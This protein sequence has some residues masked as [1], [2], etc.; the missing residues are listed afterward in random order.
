VTRVVGRRAVAL[1]WGRR[2]WLVAVAATATAAA[3]GRKPFGGRLRVRVPWA[4]SSLDPHAIG[5]PTAALFGS[6]IADPLYALDSHDRPYPTLARGLP[7]ATA[8]GALVRLRP[9][10]NTGRG[11]ALD[12]RDLLFS[13]RRARD[14]GAVALLSPFAKPVP[15]PHD[16]W[17]IVFPDAEPLAVARALT[18]PLTAL[19]PRGFSRLRPDGTGAFVASTGRK[20]LVLKRNPTAARGPAYLDAIEVT[21]ATDLADALRSFESGDADL[22]WLGR[23]L[24]RPRA[25]SIPFSAG[26]LG[27]VVLRTGAEAGSWGAPGV[28]QQLLDRI[29]TAALGHLGLHGLPNLPGDPA[30]GGKPCELLVASDAPHLVGIARTVAGVLTRPGHEIH[31]AERSRRDLAQRLHRSRF[32]LMLEFVRPLGPSSKD[33]LLS[34]L[35]AADPALARRPPRL[36]GTAPRRIAQTLP[37]GI[38]GELRIEGA[39]M[40]RTQGLANWNLGEIWQ[41]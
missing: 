18:S 7:E 34:L 27:W 17:A 35:T 5:D 33:A 37:L 21:A 30:W 23:G 8:E 9:D 22:G 25:G 19:L 26:P 6:A 36:A 12:A 24:H 16:G 41:R 31:V 13:L 32:A 28:A 11:R 20:R 1:T 29:G 3:L 15:H 40:P 39:H 4:T 10:L 14:R 2:A 38:V